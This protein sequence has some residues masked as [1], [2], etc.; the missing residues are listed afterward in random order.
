MGMFSLSAHPGPKRSTQ[1]EIPLEKHTLSLTQPPA[2][3]HSTSG[4]STSTAGTVIRFLPSLAK[5]SSKSQK[6]ASSGVSW[7]KGKGGPRAEDMLRTRQRRMG[8]GRRMRCMR[9]MRCCPR[10]EGLGWRE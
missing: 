6:R 3:R 5:S 9:C 4:I 8:C 2:I 10:G 1:P 7:M